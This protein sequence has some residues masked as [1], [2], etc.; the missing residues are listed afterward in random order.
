MINFGYI[1]LIKVLSQE[2][3]ATAEKLFNFCEDASMRLVNYNTQVLLYA[4][5]VKTV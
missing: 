5:V 3:N 4:L 2:N 1:I